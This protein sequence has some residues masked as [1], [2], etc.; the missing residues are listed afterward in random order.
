MFPGFPS[1]WDSDVCKAKVSKTRTYSR[2]VV[3]TVSILQ[4]DSL[5]ARGK[6]YQLVAET[7]AHTIHTKLVRSLRL[8]ELETQDIHGNLAGIHD[9]AEALNGIHAMRGITRT[10]RDCKAWVIRHTLPRAL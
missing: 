2:N 5:G 4:F 10:I 3:S 6:G 8:P 1:I 7:D 9:S